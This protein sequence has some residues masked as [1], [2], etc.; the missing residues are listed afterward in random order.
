MKIEIDID[1]IKKTTRCR[2]DF[3]CLKNQ[4][5]AFKTVSSAMAEEFLWIH[6][7]EKGCDYYLSFGNSTICNCPT[8]LAIYKKYGK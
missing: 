5:H 6:C 2:K 8:R 1:I 3:D 4:N 7:N